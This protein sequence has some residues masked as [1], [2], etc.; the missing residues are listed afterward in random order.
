MTASR[1]ALSIILASF[2]AATTISAGGWAVVTIDTLPEYVSAGEPVAFGY[3]VRQHGHKLLNGLSGRVI[4]TSRGHQI[5]ADA[6][7]GKRDGHYV[8]TLTFPA[9]GD[10]SLTVQ[11]GFGGLGTLSLLPLQVVDRGARPA[12][13]TASHR[14][15]QLFVAKGCATCHRVAGK[16]LPAALLQAPVLVPQKYQ[17]EYL[18]RIL[19]DPT[20]IPPVAGSGF[21][22]PDLGLDAQEI[23]ALVSFINQKS[24]Q[25]STDSQ[26]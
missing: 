14:G 19:A 6:R 21:R 16:S 24:V 15:E 9:A 4:A 22:M 20:L 17:P 5:A 7:P 1:R 13:L 2:A 3:S 18:A 26:R 10:W 11:S 8:A 23:A 12:P 25:S